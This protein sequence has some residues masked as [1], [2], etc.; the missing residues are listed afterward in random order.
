MRKILF[1]FALFFIS[2]HLFSAD[3]Q[4]KIINSD[5]KTPFEFVTVSVINK[6]T[7]KSSG[8]ALTNTQG[9]FI[10][11]SIQPGNYTLRVS[12]V[13]YKTVETEIVVSN[14][15]LIL[16]N[17]FLQEDSKTLKEVQVMG[18]GSQMRFDIDKKVFSVDQNIASAGGS[19][20]EVL[21]NIPSVNVDNE[22]NVSLRNNQNVEVWI[23]GRPSGLTADNRAQVLQQLP[24]ESIESIEIMT[25]PSA[26]FSPEGT[27]GIINLVMKKNRKA[28]YFGS[29]G[30]GMMLTNGNKLGANTS[31]SI[32]YTSNKWDMNANLGFRGMEMQGTSTTHRENFSGLDTTVLS[33]ESTSN[34]SF[35]GLFY[36]MGIDYHLNEKNTLG[37]SGF[38]ML[39][40]FNSN[41]NTDYLLTNKSNS[42]VI[43][44][45]TRLASSNGSR[46]SFH[47]NL[48]HKIDFDKKGS[49]LITDIGYSFHKMNAN[50]TYKSEYNI[51][52]SSMSNITQTG[53]SGNDEFE[54]KSDYT[55]IFKNDDKLELGWNSAYEKRNSIARG[56]NNIT[57]EDIPLYFNEFI[58]DE[59]IHAAYFTYG[60]KI[61]KF[62][63]QV[64]LRAE[65]QLRHIKTKSQE[66]NLDTFPNKD[67]QLFPS[68][69]LSYSL[70]KNNEIQ[71]N[72]S[73][74]VN[75][76]YGRQINSFRDY[77]DP[78]TVSFGNPTLT[79][80]YTSA[81]EL[82]YLKNWESHSIMASA[83]YRY[84]TDVIQQVR[85]MQ[86]GLMQS[87]SMNLTQQRNT[88]LE[89]VAKNRLLKVIN[90]TSS[91][92]LYRS[93]IDPSVYTSPQNTDI[94][95][96]GQKSFTWDAKI[97]ANFMLSR[98]I[99]GQITG[100]YIAPKI[101]NQGKQYE[102]YSVD[103]GL[104]K[105]F[106]DR[107]LI[108]AL[109]GRDIF[110]T[111]TTN[112][113]TSGEGF[114]Q[115]YISNIGG[116]PGGMGGGRMLGFNL[117]YNFGNM[118]PKMDERQKNQS[119]DMNTEMDD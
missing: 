81:F 117:T 118:K 23:N 9:S 48:N 31:A 101:I 56:K 85:F 107:K 89:L 75:R 73:R 39:G 116:G 76:P 106:F 103:F 99:S 41:N 68:M 88:G 83:Y 104:R 4:G 3:I 62:S 11:N 32:N 6:A 21:Q 58:N 109:I 22:G 93:E 36:R 15:K 10:I 90:I 84:T 94:T 19:A 53:N 91:L 60:K 46:P 52:T 87:T 5:T 105:T 18:Q 7:Q 20:T 45:F 98:T 55:K 24:A 50:S 44:D 96:N 47:V 40:G 111:R 2:F 51:P 70:P 14:Q 8:G 95:I 114:T 33:Q 12:Y 79:P 61:N 35:K 28:G 115:S 63:A 64:G 49:N 1:S 59:W 17:I 25:N 80:E 29:V 112:T 27:A 72:Y 119:Q 82:N 34:P 54:L 86:D 100:Q 77:S 13:G 108:L 66:V 30:G 97:I 37:F 113:F 57:S 67:L 78:T 110:N 16:P 74:R 71:L 65:Y 92:N 69:Y 43:T 42:E 38:G 26:K 102:V